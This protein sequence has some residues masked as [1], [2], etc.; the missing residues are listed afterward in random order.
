LSRAYFPQV[1]GATDDTIDQ[2]C[3]TQIKGGTTQY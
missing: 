1:G 2:S 3:G